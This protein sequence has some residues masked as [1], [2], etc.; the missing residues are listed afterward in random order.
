MGLR[1]K[2][3]ESLPTM[4]ILIYAMLLTC[5]IAGMA[6]FPAWGANEKTSVERPE[7][8]Y[9][10]KAGA[11]DPFFPPGTG[12]V[13]DEE[14]PVETVLPEAATPAEIIQ[15]TVRLTGLLRSGS[16]TASAAILNGNVYRPGD[17]LTVDLK[18]KTAEIVITGLYL[19][20]PR[21]TVT[22]EGEEVALSL[23]KQEE[24]DR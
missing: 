23:N 6:S 1:T 16:G 8:R 3:N 18:G 21:V 10:V 11:R 14:L 20:P 15:A 9:E 22:Y 13:N 4:R 5:I 12:R 2:R 7:P 24:K 19:D 17:V